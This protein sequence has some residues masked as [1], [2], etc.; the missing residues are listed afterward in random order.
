MTME[1]RFDN[2][3]H[4]TAFWHPRLTEKLSEAIGSRLRITHEFGVINLQKT[5]ARVCQRTATAAL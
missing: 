2:S 4:G 1:L 3:R 5:H